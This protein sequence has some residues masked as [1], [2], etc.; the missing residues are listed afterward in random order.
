M[1]REAG[2]LDTANTRGAGAGVVLSKSLLDS[3]V[4]LIGLLWIQ[5]R[6]VQRRFFCIECEPRHSSRHNAGFAST[7]GGFFLTA[8]G[9]P[10]S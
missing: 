7:E 1:S 3:V 4:P 6:T 9:Y 5:E 10:R 8:S 2:S